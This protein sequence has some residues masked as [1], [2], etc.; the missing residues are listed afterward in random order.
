MAS[1]QAIPFMNVDIL[2]KRVSRRLIPSEKG[3]K[4]A[5]EKGEKDR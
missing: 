3:E 2:G 4:G 1:C 5:S